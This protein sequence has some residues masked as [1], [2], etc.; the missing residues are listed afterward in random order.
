MKQEHVILILSESFHFYKQNYTKNSRNNFSKLKEYLSLKY[1]N[2]LNNVLNILID[3]QI[4][5]IILWFN[6]KLI[7]AYLFNMTLK[8]TH[9]EL[10]PFLYLLHT[11]CMPQRPRD[12]GEAHYSRFLV[13]GFSGSRTLDFP[14]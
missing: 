2:V 14:L 10:Y 5:F 4:K 9:L 8:S 7:N 11:Y 12:L 13:N 1:T 3:S 6:I